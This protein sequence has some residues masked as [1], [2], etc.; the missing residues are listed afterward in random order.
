MKKI[1]G[2]F[3]LVL[4]L[5]AIFGPMYF[6][7][8]IFTAKIE[9]PQI[10]EAEEAKKEPFLTEMP[11]SLEDQ[12]GEQVKK[13][14]ENS[15]GGMMPVGFA[16]KLFNLMAWSIFTMILFFGGSRVAGLGIKLLK[17]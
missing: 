14:L 11:L 1:I 6:S 8:Q 16:P 10:F 9:A 5:A 12:M 7:Y 4:G 13:M 15:V 3:L 2:W 17:P